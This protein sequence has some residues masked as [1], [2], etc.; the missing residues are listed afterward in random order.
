MKGVYTLQNGKQLDSKAFCSYFEKK[1][2]KNIRKL[3]LLN[4]KLILPKEKSIES[5]II[6]D[7][8]KKLMEKK[9]KQTQKAKKIIILPECLDDIAETILRA[10]F[11][12]DFSRQIQKLDPKFTSK[13]K[14]YARPLYFMARNEIQIY[15]KLKKLKFQE[16]KQESWLDEL[17]VKHPEIKNAI[18]NAFLK[19]FSKT[20]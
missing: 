9:K 3:Q 4:V 8:F 1:V 19:S 11:E 2:F 20:L 5:S 10:Q 13:D 6:L 17:E 15:A 7:I 16:K 12:K 18:V 14:V